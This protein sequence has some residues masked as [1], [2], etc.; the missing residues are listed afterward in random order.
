MSGLVT[1][2]NQLPPVSALVSLDKTQRKNPL[3]FPTLTLS[4][5]DSTKTLRK[6]AQSVL[7][8]KEQLQ[9]PNQTFNGT[10]RP[11]LLAQSETNST[12]EIQYPY[13]LNIAGRLITKYDSSKDLT[14]DNLQSIHSIKV[15]SGWSTSKLQELVNAVDYTKLCYSGNGRPINPAKV[16]VMKY[17]D[18]IYFVIPDSFGDSKVKECFTAPSIPTKAANGFIPQTPERLANRIS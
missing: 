3:E 1:N 15:E 12:F 9:P 18:Y 11:E 16:G 2:F 10:P 13:R 5:A 8:P 4:T 14:G 6:N 7:I 17:G